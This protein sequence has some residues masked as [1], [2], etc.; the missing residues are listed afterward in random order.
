VENK[1]FV[2][3]IS[4]VKKLGFKGAFG[5]GLLAGFLLIVVGALLSF[6]VIL[7][8]I[9]V[10]LII[11]GIFA[12]IIAPFMYK[13]SY[14]LRCGKCNAWLLIGKNNLYTKVCRKCKTIN[15]VS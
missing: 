11:A 4:K 5:L 14:H 3:D 10:P 2:H 1:E 13:N 12:P 6:T 7:A 15:K 9:G 8:I